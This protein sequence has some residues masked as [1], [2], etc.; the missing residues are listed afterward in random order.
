MLLAGALSAQSADTKPQRE[1]ADVV[2]AQASAAKANAYAQ[3]K[4]GDKKLQGKQ[5]QL[6]S[7]AARG[8]E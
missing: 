5:D 7:D 2:A 3:K 8:S 4:A 6:D 1:P